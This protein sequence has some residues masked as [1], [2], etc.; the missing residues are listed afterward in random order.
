MAKMNNLENTDIAMESAALNETKTA[1]KAKKITQ[2]EG[3]RQVSLKKFPIE[4]HDMISSYHPGAL[5]EYILLAVREQ[6]KKD[7]LL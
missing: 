2:K 4:W 5:S 1:P 7:G 6:M 3:S